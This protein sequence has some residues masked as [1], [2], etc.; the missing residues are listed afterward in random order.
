M[1]EMP[2]LEEDMS[3]IP[4]FVENTVWRETSIQ[5]GELSNMHRERKIDVGLWRTFQQLDIEQEL[6]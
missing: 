3:R 4:R 6:P 5:E 2:E 1:Y